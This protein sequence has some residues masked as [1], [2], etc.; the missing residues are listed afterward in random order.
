MNKLV[1]ILAIFIS[2]FVVAQNNKQGYIFNV[3]VDI[4]E[5]LRAMEPEKNFNGLTHAKTSK[6]NLILKKGIFDGN[7]VNR[8]L[9]KIAAEIQSNTTIDAVSYVSAQKAPSTKKRLNSIGKD[10][11]NEGVLDQKATYYTMDFFPS[12]RIKKAFES[13]SNEYYEVKIKVKWGGNASDMIV[14]NKVKKK[15]FVKY[16]IDVS[17]TA[18]NTNKKEIWKKKG[19]FHDFTKSVNGSVS[20]KFYKIDGTQ[21]LTISTIEKSISIALNFLFA[22]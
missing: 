20:K 7:E 22:Q 2:N 9:E 21:K 18:K 11:L 4:D 1:M 5:R 3:K 19:S 17:I 8:I 13:N 14:M 16:V 12:T 15:A 6:G 10:I